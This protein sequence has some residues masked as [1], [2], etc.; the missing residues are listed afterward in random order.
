MNC[1]F[2]NI[3]SG[4]INSLTLYE[5]SDVRA[6]LDIHPLTLGHTVVIPKKH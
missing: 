5:D 3:G 4:E 6:F 1:L 2:C